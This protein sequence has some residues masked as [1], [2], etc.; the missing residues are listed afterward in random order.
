MLKTSF[1]SVVNKFYPLINVS[2]FCFEFT[3]F[4]A[5]YCFHFQDH[6][7]CICMK[8]FSQLS[9]KQAELMRKK[10]PKKKPIKGVKHII[11]VAS[12]KG[13]VGKSTTAGMQI[14]YIRTV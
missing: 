4:H 13:G 2:K 6:L 14:Y 5:F 12:G 7:G 10:L 8:K 11:L 9:E 3:L 1:G